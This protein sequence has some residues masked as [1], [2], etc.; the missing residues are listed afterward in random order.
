VVKI[1]GIENLARDEHDQ[2]YLYVLH[3]ESLAPKC[4]VLC[5]NDN[6]LRKPRLKDVELWYAGGRN[7]AKLK[8]V[9]KPRLP[10]YYLCDWDNKGIE[11][12]QDIKGNIF[13]NIEL[14]I[15]QN[16]YQT[17]DIKSSWTVEIKRNLFSPQALEILDA[18]MPEKWIEEENIKHSFFNYK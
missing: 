6:K 10:L 9:P 3:C 12:Y 4:I 17:S 2:Q 15:P 8:F 13:Q 5:E 1:I 18:I 16:P 11:I 14:L 7:T